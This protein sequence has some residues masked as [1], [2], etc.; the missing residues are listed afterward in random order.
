MTAA[1]QMMSDEAL[2]RLEARMAISR[3]VDN[4]EALRLDPDHAIVRFAGGST[5][6]LQTHASWLSLEPLIGRQE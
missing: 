5:S 1:D 3:I 6:E 2:A 4:V